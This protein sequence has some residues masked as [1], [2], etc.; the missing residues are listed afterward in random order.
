MSLINQ[1]QDTLQLQLCV[2]T[3]TLSVKAGGGALRAVR[4][5]MMKTEMRKRARTAPITAPA[6]AMELDLSAWDCSESRKRLLVEPQTKLNSW[7]GTEDKMSPCSSTT[8]CKS[9]G[10]V[11]KLH[12]K[13]D[14]CC[15]LHTLPSMWTSL[16]MSDQYHT[17]QELPVRPNQATSP[18]ST[19][20]TKGRNS[21]CCSDTCDISRRRVLQLKFGWLGNS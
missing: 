14:I 5:T 19:A 12:S 21:S 11:Q 15:K 16:I 20:Q 17:L 18:S 13:K 3:Y 2:K 4:I 1:D 10:A 8:C 6:T 7:E 9:S